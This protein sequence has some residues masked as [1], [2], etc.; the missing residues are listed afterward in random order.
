MERP[1]LSQRQLSKKATFPMAWRLQL[2]AKT[3]QAQR[4][5]GAKL[6]GWLGLLGAARRLWASFSGKR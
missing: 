5:A 4:F 1:K 3:Q 6:V 2:L